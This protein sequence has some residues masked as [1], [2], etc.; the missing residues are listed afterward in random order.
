MRQS[1]EG[2]LV[3]DGVEGECVDPGETGAILEFRGPSLPGG[4]KGEQLA[5]NSGGG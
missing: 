1:R 4:G 5:S 3:T 2:V